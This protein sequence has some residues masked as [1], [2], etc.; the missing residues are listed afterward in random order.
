MNKQKLEQVLTLAKEC[1]QKSWSELDE[2]HRQAAAF[3]GDYYPASLS[4]KGKIKYDANG[5]Q[6]AWSA[7]YKMMNDAKKMIV[8]DVKGMN[9]NSMHVVLDVP[10]EHL[11]EETSFTT[12]L[13]A[14]PSWKVPKK[15]S[16]AA[17]LPMISFLS[18]QTKEIPKITNDSVFNF[19]FLDISRPL[20][21]V[22]CKLHTN[23]E[24]SKTDEAIITLYH[25][26]PESFAKICERVGFA[27][28][29]F[30]KQEPL[31]APKGSVTYDERFKQSYV[32]SYIALAAHGRYLRALVEI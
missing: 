7:S 11:L 4:D 8:T 21:D 26:H 5:E 24:L 28:D 6:S 17:H 15:A 1:N 3:V 27:H 31:E 18:T 22:I 29:I 30:K 14:F 12:A 23:T 25:D 9:A 16:L 2:I 20:S 19:S 32:A 10:M 13:D